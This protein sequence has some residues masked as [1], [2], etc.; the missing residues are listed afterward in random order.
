L[1]VKVIGIVGYKNSGKTR[2][3]VRLSQELSGMGY[4]VGVIKH[5][6]DHLDF[7]ETD[8]TKFKEHVPFVA[9]ISKDET[10]IIVKGRKRIE[11]VIGFFDC[12][13]VLVE[14]FKREKT[15]PKIVCLKEES[16]REEL[17]D[18]L[19]LLTAGFDGGIS[20]FAIENDDHIK[21]MAAIAAEKAFKLP[22]LNCGHCDYESCFD[23]AREIVAGKETIDKCVSLNPP[24]SVEVGG[25]TLPLNPFTS[26]LMKNAILGMLSTLKGFKKGTVRIEIPEQNS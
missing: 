24:I 1:E 18:G 12:D 26:N 4:R 5:A 25:T 7:P 22:S 21:R 11:N 6:P 19:Q 3:I 15:F 14:G 8:T 20:D 13:I 10:E 23:L 16:D 9:G 2:L 17:F